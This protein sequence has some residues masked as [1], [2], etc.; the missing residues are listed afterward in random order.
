LSSANAV[1]DDEEFAYLFTDEPSL[2]FVG[3][4]AG[5]F[6]KLKM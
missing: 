3:D 5:F 2:F 6:E 1:V 4:W